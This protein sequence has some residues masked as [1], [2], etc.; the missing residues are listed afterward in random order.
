MLLEDFNVQIE[1]SQ[2]VK[3]Y[4][5]TPLF[6]SIVS[7]QLLTCQPFRHVRSGSS[8][9]SHGEDDCG[10]ATYNIAAGKDLWLRALHLLVDDDGV[11]SSQFQS[12]D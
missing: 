4:F 6:F 10:S 11:F 2:V 9:V 8:A 5:D 3:L 12:L 7:Q 1:S